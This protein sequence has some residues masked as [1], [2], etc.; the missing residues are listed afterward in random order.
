MGKVLC[1]TCHVPVSQAGEGAGIGAA[2]EVWKGA[3][4]G[5]RRVMGVEVEEDACE[6]GDGVVAGMEEDG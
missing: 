1:V 6:V 2:E 4:E 3:V 5:G